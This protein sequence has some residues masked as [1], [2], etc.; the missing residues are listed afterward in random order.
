MYIPTWSG[1]DMKMVHIPTLASFEQLLSTRRNIEHIPR[2]PYREPAP[3]DKIDLCITPGLV[4][5]KFGNRVGYGFG[6]YDKYLAEHETVWGTRPN[7]LAIAHDEQVIKYKISNDV[8][9]VEVQVVA[10][11]SMIYRSIRI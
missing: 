8:H 5:D 11:P 9:D 2:P 7:L 4:F 1:G 10:T 3:L 6:H